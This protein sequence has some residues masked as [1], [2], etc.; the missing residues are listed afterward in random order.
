MP[1]YTSWSTA[2]TNIQ[3]AVDW[4]VTGDQVLVTNGTYQGTSRVSP[5]GITN[6]VVITNAVSL[7][8]VNGS[9]VTFIDGSNSV[10]GVYLT[11]GAALTGFTVLKGKAT[12]TYGGGV[13]C[14]STDCQVSGCLITYN[15]AK[16]GGGI[17]SGIVSNCTISSNVVVFAG[18]GGG[19]YNSTLLNCILTGNS[20]TVNGGSGAGAVGGFLSN[21][22]INNNICNGS[23]STVG[24]GVSGSVLTNCTLTGN[25]VTGA[26]SGGGGAYASVLNNC[27]L[28]N[29]RC[30]F[31]G[32]GAYNCTL[33][34][35]TLASNIASYG[36]GG[37]SGGT[38]VNCVLRNNTSLGGYGGG[39]YW[40]TTLINCTLVGN[41]AGYGGGGY[42]C[43]FY[44][45]IVYYNSAPNGANTYGC[46]FNYCCTT[47]SG[48][49][50]NT[51][52]APF[53]A[54]QPAGD[55][56]LQSGSGGIDAGA[57]FYASS[58]TDFDGNLRIANGTVDMGAF[59]YEQPNPASVSILANYTNVVV[60]ITVSFQG[61]FSRGKTDSWNFGDSTV[62]S[63]QIFTTHSWATPGDYPVTLTIFDSSNPGGV[64]GVYVIHVTLRHYPT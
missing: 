31:G 28:S 36:G 57:N 2:A 48:G 10:R 51:T 62:I 23:G 6:R 34:N 11:N 29:N 9:A 3:D 30:D 18:S 63:N 35:C 26:G 38:L 5:D 43:T 64:S 50:G 53:F 4:A 12:T 39:V 46:T 56:H 27:T 60:G 19:A 37:V 24:G 40:T 7:Q 55:F 22:A 54:N 59:E 58:L 8:S 13:C 25:R 16:Y 45:C 20:T 15:S 1:P 52:N 41:S 47:D 42:S 44:N 32:G 49:V 17:Y 33:T 61:V 14:A 21:C